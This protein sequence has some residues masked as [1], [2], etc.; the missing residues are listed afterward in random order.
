MGLLLVWGLPNMTAPYLIVSDSPYAPSGYG[1]SARLLARKMVEYGYPVRYFGT[2]YYGLTHVVD[3][4]ELVG[5]VGDMFGNDLMQAYAADCKAVITLK[6]VQVYRPD[7]LKSLN[8]AWCPIVMIDTEPVSEAVKW[9]LQWAFMPI[10]VT[11]HSLMQLHENHIPSMYAPLGVDTSVYKP[12]NQAQARQISQLPQDAFIVAFVGANQS[13][14]SR[15]GLDKAIA[16]YAQIEKKIPNSFLYLHT[17]ATP[18]RGGI[19]VQHALQYH[20]VKRFAITS[21][22]DYAN[23]LPPAKMVALYN[24]ADVLLN[25]SRGGGF[26]LC[27]VEAQACGVP[28]ISSNFTAMRETVWAGWKLQPNRDVGLTYEPNLVAYRFEPSTPHLVQAL[29]EAYELRNDEDL[30]VQAR[31]GA[32]AYDIDHVFK[33][34]WI[35]ALKRIE[36]NLHLFKSEVTA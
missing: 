11:R 17:D 36:K 15:K 5:G 19:N 13:N 27:G 25:P 7:V 33:E 34:Y 21:P 23:G 8:K 30:K 32:L 29:L 2:T 12:M 26:E 14:P 1:I 31:Q 18:Q 10:S 20:G 3:G 35:P 28:V 4:F 9:P 6:D 22:M 16:A 24:S